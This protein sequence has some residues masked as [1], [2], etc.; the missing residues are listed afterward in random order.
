MSEPP[1]TFRRNESFFGE[2]PVERFLTNA[3]ADAAA[4]AAA[5]RATLANA[6]STN[7]FMTLATATKL[8]KRLAAIEAH[9]WSLG[10]GLTDSPMGLPEFLPRDIEMDVKT[11]E[12]AVEDRGHRVIGEKG[13]AR[14]TRCALRRSKDNYRFFYVEYVR[15]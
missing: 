9:R 13:W 8:V 15:G 2:I 3:I 14:C 7:I 10:D 11:L 12:K 1:R 6:G 4:G 5:E